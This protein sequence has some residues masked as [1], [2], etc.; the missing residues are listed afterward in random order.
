MIERTLRALEGAGRRE[1]WSGLD[2]TGAFAWRMG[3]DE[4]LVA[5]GGWQELLRE[6]GIS[7]GDRVGLD[8]GRGADLLPAHLAVL[9]AGACVVPVNRALSPREQERVFERAELAC[10]LRP[11]DAPEQRSNPKLAPVNPERPA[12]L[13]FTSGTTGEPKGVPLSMANLE[14]N[15]AA[16]ASTWELSGEDRLLQALPAHHVHG[17]VLA[18]Y[19]SARLALPVVM[20]PRFDAGPALAA[21]ADHA[22]T[23]FMG[24]PTMYHRMVHAEPAAKLPKMR[25][26]ISGSAPLAPRDF[27]AFRTRFGHEP[28]ER[29]GLSETLIVSSNPVRGVRRPGTVGQ[30]LP[31]AE[32]RFATDGEILVRGP[33]VMR[34]Y[35]REPERDLD[36]FED[37]YFRTGDLGSH[38]DAGYL[39]IS[40]RKKELILVGGSNVTPGE[41]ERALAEET[42]V[43]ELA[44]A[45]IPDPDRGEVV[46]AFVVPRTGT[47]P[48]DLEGRLRER[49]EERL[50]AYKRPRL[51]RFLPELPRNAMGK[52]DRKRLP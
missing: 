32:L 19:G 40:G 12:L 29:Y 16:L 7:P 3:A 51:Y 34:G 20:L 28:V 30:P 13:I 44:V 46:A 41:V 33:S 10:L 49:A 18:V 52:L 9:A 39:V 50:A 42:G 24:V 36:A 23:V 11:E 1:V 47:D 48:R 38:D 5:T 4:L 26:F 45:G 14:A 17:L 2:S 35:W 6:R 25:V 15:L 31:G 37:E 8:L 43:D 22:I 21:L 27:T